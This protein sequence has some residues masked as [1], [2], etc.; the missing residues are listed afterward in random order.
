LAALAEQFSFFFKQC[1]QNV[2]QRHQQSIFQELVEQ[3]CFFSDAHRFFSVAKVKQ[4]D[5]F[6]SLIFFQQGQHSCFRGTSRAFF[7]SAS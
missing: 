6:T 3:S 4:Y 1:L 5:F 7:S 2:F